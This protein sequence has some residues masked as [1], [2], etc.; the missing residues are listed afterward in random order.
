[1]LFCSSAAASSDNYA[2]WQGG[3]LSTLWFIF[4]GS[5]NVET[6]TPDDLEMENDGS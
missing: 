2:R 6:Q 3:T 1:M 4:D 5:R